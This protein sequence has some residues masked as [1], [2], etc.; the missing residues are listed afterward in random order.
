M[1]FSRRSLL[2]E[3]NALEVDLA[4]RIVIELV[5]LGLREDGTAR[6]RQERLGVHEAL[7]LALPAVPTDLE[8]LQDPVAV[9]LHRGQLLLAAEEKSF[10][11]LLQ[12]L[13]VADLRVGISLRLLEIRLLLLERCDEL[14]RSTLLVRV[15]GLRLLLVLDAVL[16]P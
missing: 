12:R 6:A 10:R 16:D 5:L 9:R 4:E 2:Q 7:H 13:G 8:V 15:R 3:G 1:L 11:V 14:L